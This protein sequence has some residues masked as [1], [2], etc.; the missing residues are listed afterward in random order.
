MPTIRRD[1]L[2][3][4]ILGTD[5]AYAGKNGSCPSYLLT[6]RGKHYLIDAGPG[7]V[8][9]FQNSIRF[10]DISCIFLSH[11]HADHVSDIYTLR[12]GVYIAQKEKGMIHKPLIYLPKRPRDTYRFIKKNIS[13]EFIIKILSE[14]THVELDGL[15]VS[16]MR[17]MHPIPAYAM[18]FDAEIKG[19]SAGAQNE[20][21][22]STFVYTSDTGFFEGLVH[23]SAQASVILSEATFQSADEKLTGMGHMTAEKAG[24]FA[25][26]SGADRLVLTHIMPEYDKSV[27]AKEA[28]QTF[29]KE[30]TIAERGKE[31]TI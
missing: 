1:E 28:K 17:T 25:A 19:D 22:V 15:K 12:Y 6:H 26:K 9:A 10:S 21:R 24:S 4:T 14:K 29:H 27:S 23:F 13:Q 3:L 2:K 5:A 20:K 8:S 11:L 7:C 30:V 16:F 18:R 31:L